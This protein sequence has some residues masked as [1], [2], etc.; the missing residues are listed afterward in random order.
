MAEL[1]GIDRGQIVRQLP[2][3]GRRGGTGPGR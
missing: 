2:A 3:G 1:P